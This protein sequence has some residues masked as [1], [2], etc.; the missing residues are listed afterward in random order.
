VLKMTALFRRPK[1]ARADV[2]VFT[3]SPRDVALLLEGLPAR[4]VVRKEER[5]G[6]DAWWSLGP[7]SSGRGNMFS[8][9]S[10][11]HAQKLVTAVH[12]LTG[13]AMGAR[14]AGGS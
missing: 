3:L 11:A 9:G 7:D 1:F 2:P 5:C 14:A 8:V 6:G 10:L 4:V 12:L 13:R